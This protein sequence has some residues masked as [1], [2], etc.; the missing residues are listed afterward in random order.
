MSSYVRLINLIY[1]STNRIMRHVLLSILIGFILVTCSPP[2][3]ENENEEDTMIDLD[4]AAI[5]LD[6]VDY[7]PNEFESALRDDTDIKSPG[8]M[9]MGRRKYD[10]YYKHFPLDHSDQ[11]LLLLFEIYPYGL[12]F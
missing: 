3:S 8:E 10:R 5:Q 6:T 4:T 1:L 11:L 7:L 12:I 2:E 9:R